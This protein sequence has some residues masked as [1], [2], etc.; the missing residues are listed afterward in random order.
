MNI[1]EITCKLERIFPPS[2]FNSMEHLTI[3]LPYRQK[4]EDLFNIDGC[5]HLNGMFS[6]H[7]IFYYF[8]FFPKLIDINDIGI[9]F[10]RRKSD[11]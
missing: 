11:Q 2:F 3:N 5:I 8:P 9:C 10:I 1:I 6:C 4:S 7:I